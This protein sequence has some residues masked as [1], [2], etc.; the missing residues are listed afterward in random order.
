V[1]GVLA[2][3]ASVADHPW[4]RRQPSAWRA[5]EFVASLVVVGFPVV[6]GFAV[7]VVLPWALAGAGRVALV[8]A[9]GG[10]SHPVADV[11]AGVREDGRAGILAALLAACMALPLGLIAL[12]V[13]SL[14]DPS[15]TAGMRLVLVPVTVLIAAWVVVA[16]LVGSATETPSRAVVPGA[17]A[18]VMGSPGR[19]VAAGLIASAGAVPVVAGF[20]PAVAALVAGWSFL[21]AVRVAWPPVARAARAATAGSAA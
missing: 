19:S 3:G 10:A 11:V 20:D 5:A 9:R 1:N 6:L 15:V 18:V 17:L 7:P 13:G 21:T 4:E 16:L 12:A 14:A 8:R 2:S